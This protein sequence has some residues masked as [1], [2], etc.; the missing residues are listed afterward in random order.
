VAVMTANESL[1]QIIRQ[2]VAGR[3]HRLHEDVPAIGVFAFKVMEVRCSGLYD[4]SAF[5]HIQ[6]G[7]TPT[8]QKVPTE[9]ME[10]PFH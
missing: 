8:A 4:P 2:Q 9:L 3:I 1:A 7:Q 5:L 6:N 10:K